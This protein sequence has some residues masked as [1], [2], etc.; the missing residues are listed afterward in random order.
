[1]TSLFEAPRD[2][3]RTEAWYRGRDGGSAVS[4]EVDPLGSV[5]SEAS[6]A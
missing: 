1:M 4:T 2:T 5:H 6:R 3:A